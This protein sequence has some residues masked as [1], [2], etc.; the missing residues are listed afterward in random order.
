MT[1]KTTAR[2]RA[3]TAQSKNLKNQDDYLAASV[4]KSGRHCKN[5]VRQSK[6][7]RPTPKNASAIK[8]QLFVLME[9]SSL[10][11]VPLPVTARSIPVL[12]YRAEKRLK[13]F[14]ISKGTIRF[15]ADKPFAG[16]AGA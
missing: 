10:P 5:F 3:G 7:R 8:C 13:N 9:N 1:G 6:Q 12:R 14:I 4:Q 2:K 11:T 16:R 15:P